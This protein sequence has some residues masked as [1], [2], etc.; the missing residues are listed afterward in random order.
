MAKPIKPQT[1][2]PTTKTGKKLKNTD[3][4]L[5]KNYPSVTSTQ[6]YKDLKEG[7]KSLAKSFGL[8]FKKGGAV[9]NKKKKK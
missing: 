2:K 4:Y 8:G 1:F 9:K 3:D 6:T 5:E 7:V